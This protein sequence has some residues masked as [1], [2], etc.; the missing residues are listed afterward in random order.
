MSVGAHKHEF[1][2]INGHWNSGTTLLVDL[3][4]KHP[5]L[6]FRQA[7]YKPELEERTT[8]KLLR[9]LG[10]PAIPFG[11]NYNQ[12]TEHNG[13]GYWQEPQLAQDGKLE[14]FSRQ[15]HRKFRPRG[16]KKALL[17]NPWLL[18]YPHTLKA[19]TQEDHTHYIYILR[20][21]R[22]QV[23]SRDYWKKE[24]EPEKHLI[25]R[26]HFWVYCMQ[27]FLDQWQKDMNCLVVRYENLTA[28]PEESLQEICQHAQ[29]PFAPLHEHLP[30]A[31]ENR[32]G[33]WHALPEELRQQVEAI[34]TPMQKQQDT[35]Y[36]VR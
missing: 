17:K 26:A 36:P 24:P 23:T 29:I 34:I 1:L 13:F 35:L 16:G 4:R 3:L 22:S 8:L 5:E 27:W 9:K 18:F 12:V 28:H 7:R 32:L 11:V 21:G 2:I 15:W 19:L 14:Q 6:D 20:D 31:L 33:K 10:Y 25:A 30:P